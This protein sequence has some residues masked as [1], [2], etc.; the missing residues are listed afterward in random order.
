MHAYTYF[1]F[2]CLCIYTPTSIHIDTA[3]YIYIYTYTYSISI[4]TY[5]YISIYLSL[6][7][8]TLKI[9]GMETARPRETSALDPGF[10]IYRGVRGAQSGFWVFFAPKMGRK[11]GKFQG[12]S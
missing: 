5:T 12:N 11:R 3:M 7:V 2:S 10:V 6:Y 4:Y 9:A 8:Y 1:F